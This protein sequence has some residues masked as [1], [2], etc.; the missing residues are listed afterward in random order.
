MVL[1]NAF[2]L[3]LLCS[4]QACHPKLMTRTSYFP[5]HIEPAVGPEKKGNVWVFLMAGQ[6]NMAG[7]GLVE[8]PDTMPLQRLLSIDQ[9]G[10]LILA[11]EPLHFY[12]PSLAGLDCG[13]AFGKTL[14]Q[15][16][17]D[18]VSVLLIPTA[19]GGSSISQWLGDSIY[20]QVKLFSNFKEKVDIAKQYGTIK[21]V[22]WHQG[23]SDANAHDI[24]L[25]KERLAEL[26]KRFRSVT[27][28]NQLPVLLGELGPF[29][30]D[31]ENWASLNK[32]IHAYTAEDKNTTVI[33][34]GDL[35]D[36]GDKIH[37]N[38]KGQRKLGER[39]ANAFLMI[40]ESRH[41]NRAHE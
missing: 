20:R 33:A 26:V 7:R 35:K 40:N 14:L 23:E 41:Q 30:T 8:P 10:R 4:I 1:A 31:K 13:Y 21:A 15:N 38:S 25:Y 16:I 9:N 34:T 12:E 39:F 3:F 29:S 2:L 37:F 17:P 5:K 28:N 24:P 22:L 27:G 36:K 19:V 18:S 11:K 32:A 6:S